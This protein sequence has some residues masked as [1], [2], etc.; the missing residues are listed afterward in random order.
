MTPKTPVLTVGATYGL[1]GSPKKQER[2]ALLTV[3]VGK[4]PETEREDIE[5]S[6]KRRR[7]ADRKRGAALSTWHSL[8]RPGSPLE[9]YQRLFETGAPKTTYREKKDAD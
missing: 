9:R 6:R 1:Q 8:A 7:E 4:D 5:E 2:P 3:L